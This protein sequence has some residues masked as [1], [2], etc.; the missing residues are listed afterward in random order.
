MLRLVFPSNG[1]LGSDATSKNSGEPQAKINQLSNYAATERNPV[2][3]RLVRSYSSFLIA[4]LA[5]PLYARWLNGSGRL[6][7]FPSLTFR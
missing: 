7:S 3:A 1:C 2:T 5:G 6:T 4:A